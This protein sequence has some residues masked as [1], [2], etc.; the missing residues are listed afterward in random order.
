MPIPLLQ[1]DKLDRLALCYL[2]KRKGLSHSGIAAGLGVHRS[3]V[4]N[5]IAGRRKNARVKRRILELLSL[6]E[7]QVVFGDAKPEEGRACQA[8]R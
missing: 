4:S 5:T 3:L 7:D 6:R 8:N 1:T 2:L